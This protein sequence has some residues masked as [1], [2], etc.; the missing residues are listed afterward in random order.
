MLPRITLPSLVALCC[1]AN[2]QQSSQ[3]NRFTAAA[4]LPFN[5]SARFEGSGAL[6]A[7]T[8]PGPSTGTTVPR[9]YDDGYVRVDS[10]GNAGGVTWYWGYRDA[11]QVAGDDTLRMHSS[12]AAADGQSTAHADDPSLGFEV[13]YLREFSRSGRFAWGLRAS[14]AYADIDIADSQSVLSPAQQLTDVYPLN[15]IIP[16]GDPSLPGWQYQGAYDLPGPV[17]NSEP[18]ARQSATVNDGAFTTGRRDLDTSLFV[19]KLGPWIEL[20]L[21][22]RLWATAGGGLA[23]AYAE[24]DFAF[25]ETTTVAGAGNVAATGHGTDSDVQVGAYAQVGLGF[26]LSTRWSL[27]ALGEYQYLAEFTTEVAG[28]RATLDLGAVWSLQTGIGFSF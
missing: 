3:P 25:N 26:N 14:F 23:I 22:Q 2:G 9:E 6:A 16:P 12:S 15:G 17:I 18:Q 1:T 8:N 7:Q 4:W 11:A 27:F 28:H 24:S 13:A 19:W 5:V 20:P 21:T 10:D